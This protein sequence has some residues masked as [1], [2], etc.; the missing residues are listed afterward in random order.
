MLKTFRMK[1][2][3]R[4]LKKM[5]D[6]ICA[7]DLETTGKYWNSDAPI[8]I[9]AEIINRSG[10]VID[11]FN[12]RIKTTHKIDPEASLVHHI[13]ARDLV[14]CPMESQVLSEFMAWLQMNAPD[15]LLT[16]N[17]KTFDIP[18]LQMRCKILNIPGHNLFDLTHYDCK[19]D[20]FEAKRRDMFDLKSLGRK[21]KLTLVA[22][23]L[24]INPEGAHDAFVDIN[25]LKQVWFK[26]DP[27]LFPEHWKTEDEI[28]LF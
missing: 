7:I 20:V 3:E 12:Q 28:S 21:W 5:F 4:N 24:G 15:A 23:K 19:E 2:L 27:I 14:N 16:Y 26:L 8:Q 11:T 9:A 1:F 22:E 18:M 13:Y 17:G 10:E 25:L 6:N